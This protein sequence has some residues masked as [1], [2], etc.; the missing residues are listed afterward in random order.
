MILSALVS[1]GGHVYLHPM[2]R[3]LLTQVWDL[4]FGILSEPNVTID[5]DIHRNRVLSFE[6][7]IPLLPSARSYTKIF[8]FD[9]SRWETDFPIWLMTGDHAAN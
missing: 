3:P 9:F 1:L 4:S 2:I 6:S 5:E 7:K 8:Y